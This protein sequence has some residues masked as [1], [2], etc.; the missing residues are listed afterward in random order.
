M[1]ME[2]TGLSKIKANPVSTNVYDE[3]IARL[4]VFAQFDVENKKTS[5]HIVHGR[6]F[7]GVH[8]RK[9]GLLLNIVTAEP[10]M[11]PRIKKAERVSANRC[12]NEIIVTSVHALDEELM[13]W[14]EQA[15]AL[16]AAA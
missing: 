13:A 3:L 5:L 9:D 14:I 10:L 12:H 11:S 1:V 2:E 4:G 15:Y 8:P 7:L 16:T 6:A